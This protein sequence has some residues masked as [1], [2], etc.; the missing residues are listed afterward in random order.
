VTRGERARGEPTRA[1]VGIMGPRER[2]CGGVRGAKPLGV[3]N[4]RAFVARRHRRNT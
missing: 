3:I 4:V 2:A 1:G